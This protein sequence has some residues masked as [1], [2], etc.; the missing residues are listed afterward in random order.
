MV[1]CYSNIRGAGTPKGLQGQR[2]PADVIG[3][4]IMVA[5][6]ATGEIA[7][8]IEPDDGKDPAAKAL[9]RKGAAPGDVDTRAAPR[10][11]QEGGS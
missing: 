5:R 3:N 2:R 7:E 10:D 9:G 6:I 4:T 1:P 11:R 8:P